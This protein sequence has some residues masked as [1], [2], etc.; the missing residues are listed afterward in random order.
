MRKVIILVGHGQ[1]PRDLSKEIR[2]EYFKLRAKPRKNLDE[3]RLYEELERM[4][5]NWPRNNSNDPYWNSLHKLGDL[6]RLHGEYDV[7][8]AFNEF[9]APHIEE[10]LEDA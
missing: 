5:R 9:C 4:I 6:I 8:V 2:E 1:L 10:A 3:E 7:V